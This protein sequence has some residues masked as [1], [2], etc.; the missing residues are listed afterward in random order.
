MTLK[1]IQL[2]SIFPKFHQV[3]NFN[4][5]KIQNENNQSSVVVLQ[6]SQKITSNLTK[7][8]SEKEDIT[9]DHQTTT[10]N[11]PLRSVQGFHTYTP[12]KYQYNQYEEG[13]TI[14]TDQ[15]QSIT[16]ATVETT[17][18]S[19]KILARGLNLWL[20]ED[21]EIEPNSS[22]QQE[23]K[24][25]SKPGSGLT[26]AMQSLVI[27]PVESTSD[28][29]EEEGVLPEPAGARPVGAGR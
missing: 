15:S 17:D 24:E 26:R 5:L 12:N 10:A 19:D 6:I 21:K 9:S 14:P 18:S 1:L 23:E 27:Q 8:K 29:D 13:P 4:N 16:T 25:K 3:Q 7:L 11:E 2:H 28:D 22:S 20:H